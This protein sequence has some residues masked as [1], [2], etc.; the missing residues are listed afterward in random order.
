MTFLR[1]FETEFV[2]IEL[3]DKAM[4]TVRNYRRVVNQ[5]LRF[6]GGDP[7][8]DD[9]HA[10]LLFSYEE[11]L[12]NR[13]VKKR[14][15]RNERHYVWRIMRTARPDDFQL[16][17][18]GV[19]G[20]P[21]SKPGAVP[22]VR[23]SIQDFIDHVYA[24]HHVNLSDGGRRQIIYAA[25]SLACFHE[26]T[27]FVDQLSETIVLPWVK[28]LTEHAA[29]HTASRHRSRIFTVWRFAKRRG[30]CEAP[31]PDVERIRLPKRIPKAWTLDEFESILRQSLTL[32][33]TIKD[34]GIK[35]ADWWLSLFL[36]LYDTGSRIGAALRIRPT[37]LS[38]DDGVCVLTA[39]NA[40]TGLEQAVRISDQ[41]LGAIL[42]HYSADREFVFPWPYSGRYLFVESKRILKA[43]GVDSS[44]YVG[45]HRVRKTHATQAVI[46]SG[47]EQ[48]SRDLGH[49]SVRMTEAYVDTRQV[50][51]RVNLP[52]PQIDI[53][54]DAA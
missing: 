49:T 35:R 27:V 24:T 33:G 22:K 15:A 47:W 37:D 30:Y 53:T 52:R 43:A 23:L 29:M 5:F 41:T 18:R 50:D 38:L 32:T 3:K 11:H 39:D 42:R 26:R 21:L 16:R 13:G 40:K 46:A 9:I 36:F 54:E 14:N 28:H 48:A 7:K 25:N 2:P 17:A 34:S 19:R 31:V 12:I 1:Y 51:R 6:I 10:G 45:F 20:I 8:L 4:V 44:R